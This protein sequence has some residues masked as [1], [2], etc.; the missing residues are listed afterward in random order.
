MEQCGAMHKDAGY[1]SVFSDTEWEV[2]GKCHL[3]RHSALYFSFRAAEDQ[4][5]NE[6]HSTSVKCVEEI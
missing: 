5:R 6:E 2:R 3:S 4:L 1:S